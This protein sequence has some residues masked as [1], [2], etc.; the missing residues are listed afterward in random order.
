MNTINRIVIVLVLVVLAITMTAVF[1]LPHV[2]LSQL[3]EWFSAWG[4]YF[5][6]FKYPIVRLGLGVLLAAGFDV[7]V[8][9]LIFLE[10]RGQRK[11]FIR[12]QQ[13]QGGMA[14]VSSESI[15]Q[16]LKYKLDPVPGVLEVKP[17]LKAKGD[18]VQAQVEVR[19]A[20]GTNVPAM[21]RELMTMVRTVL[22]EDLGLQVHGEPEVRI[23][24]ASGPGQAPQPTYQQPSSSSPPSPPEL[25]ELERDSDEVHETSEEDVGHEE[26]AGA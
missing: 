25:P 26:G 22:V 17:N 6:Q 24:V 8:L 19:V 12:V 18:Q 16:Q 13:V 23:K 10:V 14:T 9:L 5:Y 21:A 1:I 3:G 11:R 20:P 15:T 2:I 4:T 7:A